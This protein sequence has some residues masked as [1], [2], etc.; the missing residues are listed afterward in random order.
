MNTYTPDLSELR[1]AY[2]AAMRI[3]NAMSGRGDDVAKSGEEFDRGIS[4]VKAEAWDE[5]NRTAFEKHCDKKDECWDETD[6]NP[7]R[8]E[9]DE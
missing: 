9:P 4:Q 8:E 7:Y 5:G 3:V 2:I 6:D 1:D